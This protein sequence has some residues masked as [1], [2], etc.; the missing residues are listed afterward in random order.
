MSPIISTYILSMADSHRDSLPGTAFLTFA[1]QARQPTLT[2]PSKLTRV[3]QTLGLSA[4]ATRAIVTT[5]KT[6][7]P[8]RHR[9]HRGRNTANLCIYVFWAA[10]GTSL[11]TLATQARQPIRTPLHKLTR[12]SRTLEFSV[13]ATETITITVTTPRLQRYRPHRGSNTLN[14][15]IYVLWNAFATL[16]VDYLGVWLLTCTPCPYT[17]RC[18]PPCVASPFL[19]LPAPYETSTSPDSPSACAPSFP[20]VLGL[21]FVACLGTQNFC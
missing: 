13:A 19:L 15:R 10:P 3:R 9:P 17:L 21:V 7:H 2:R 20:N 6:P 12:A 18:T 4:V 5:I 11:L 14:Q 16:H 1:T 8:Q